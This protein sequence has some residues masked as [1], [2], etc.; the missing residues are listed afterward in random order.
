MVMVTDSPAVKTARR[1][2]G[3]LSVTVR[4][5]VET[6]LPG[7]DIREV[8]VVVHYITPDT[9]EVLIDGKV[10]GYIRYDGHHFVALTGHRIQDAQQ[11][12]RTTD[13]WDHAVARLYAVQCQ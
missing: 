6:L 7:S 11:C 1:P 8:P 13:L 3:M 5:P 2:Q 4:I 10:I 12:G 9:T